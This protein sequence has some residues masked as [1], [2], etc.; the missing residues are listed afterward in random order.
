MK[1]IHFWRYALYGDRR[2]G[3]R[4]LSVYRAGRGYRIH[5]GF[6]CGETSSTPH[7]GWSTHA[8]VE[9]MLMAVAAIKYSWRE[10]GWDLIRT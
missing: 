2:N 9:S 5:R 7:D 3:E 6:H 8:T 4:S 10:S 1:R